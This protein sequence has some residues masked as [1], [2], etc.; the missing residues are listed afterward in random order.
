MLEQRSTGPV[1]VSEGSERRTGMD[2]HDAHPGCAETVV[3]QTWGWNSPRVLH[4]APWRIVLVYAS[5][6]TSKSGTLSFLDIPRPRLDVPREHGYDR[7]AGV[8]N[9]TERPLS[10][11]CGYDAR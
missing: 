2:S 11:V 8:R 10:S 9:I 6:H 4:A 5:I 1:A 7:G 3:F